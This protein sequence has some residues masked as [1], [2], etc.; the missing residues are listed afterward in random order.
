M[1]VSD[2]TLR[3]PAAIAPYGMKGEGNHTCST[4]H[5]TACDSRN[6]KVR[7]SLILFISPGPH[8][9]YISHDE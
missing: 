5:S 8:D 1:T 3:I 9:I 4:V 6:G 2:A 7:A